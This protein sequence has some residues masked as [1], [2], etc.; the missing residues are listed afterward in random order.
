MVVGTES[1]LPKICLKNKLL[2]GGIHIQLCSAGGRKWSSKDGTEEKVMS[3]RNL[4]L[5]F[6]IILGKAW[7]LCTPV[8]GRSMLSRRES[9]SSDLHIAKG[10]LG[11]NHDGL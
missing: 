3:A 10:K 9:T 6:F 8:R 1:S 4:E 11:D 7:C 5:V 2:Y